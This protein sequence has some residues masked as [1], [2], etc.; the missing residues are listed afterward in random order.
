MSA[1]KRHFLF[2]N[3]GHLF[4]HF[5]MLVFTTAVLTME[6][7]FKDSYGQLLALTTWGFIFFGGAS[8]PAGWLGD[9]WSQHGMMLV[10]F[11][12]IGAASVLTGFST[13]PGHVE[14]GLALIGV[15]GAIYHP[16]GLALVV[17]ESDRV[18]RVLAINGVWGNMGVASAA[19][20][21]GAIAEFYGWRMAF[22]LPGIVAI[23]VGLLYGWHLWSAGTATHGGGRKKANLAVPVSLQRRTFIFLLIAPLFGGLIFQAT[24]VALPKIMAV[25]L[26][27]IFP[28]TAGIGGIT[29]LVFGCAAFAQL[30]VGELLDRYSAKRVYLAL[31]ASQMAFL[32]L[33]VSVTGWSTV[34]VTLPLMLATFGVVPINDWIVAHYISNEYRSRVYAVKSLFSLGVAAVA[35]QVTKELYNSTGNF[36]SLFLVLAGSAAVVFATTLLLLPGRAQLAQAPAAAE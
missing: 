9:R 7:E 5:F 19:L 35:V 36:D 23:V 25:R 28:D 26:E 21:T 4:D 10:F 14:I 17:K 20:T 32:L 8:I 34:A 11:L 22:I 33:A 16:I 2:L 27:S 29:A 13:T 30:T 6:T 3:L 18:G 24:T 12:G 31:L 1:N 15:F